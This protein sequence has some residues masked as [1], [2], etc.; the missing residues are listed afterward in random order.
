MQKVG[1]RQLRNRLSHYLKRAQSGET[2]VVTDRGTSVAMLLPPPSEK[3]PDEALR[4]L[5]AEG[6]ASW[7]GGKPKGAANPPRVGGKSAAEI[8]IEE[9][10]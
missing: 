7:A 9:R 6:R 3:D 1:V 10:G 5:V 4:R 8:V 2:V